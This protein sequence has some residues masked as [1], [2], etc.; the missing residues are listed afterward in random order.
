MECDAQICIELEIAPSKISSSAVAW[1][2]SHATLVQIITLPPATVL[3]WLF[4]TPHAIGRL[5]SAYDTNRVFN[6]LRWDTPGF[7]GRSA[8]IPA[9]ELENECRVATRSR[10][11]LAFE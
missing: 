1:L 10:R 2:A 6:Q 11:K 8:S 3:D 7:N 4:E 5:R 9:T